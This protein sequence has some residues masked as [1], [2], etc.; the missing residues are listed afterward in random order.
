MDKIQ[1]DEIYNQTFSGLALFYRDTN[2]PE[3]LISKYTVGQILQE[4]G[5]T[6]MTFKVGGLTTNLRY[7]IASAQA[8]DLSAFNPVSANFGLCLLPAGAFFKVLDIYRIGDKTQIFMLDIPAAAVGFFTVGSTNIEDG[9]IKKAREN[10]ETNFNAP[11]VPELQ[12]DEWKQRTEFPVGMSDK[13]EFFYNPDTTTTVSLN[14]TDEHRVI[15]AKRE[16]QQKPW[17]KFW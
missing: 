15:Q 8:T 10:F 7:L 11:P 6:D 3:E 14:S 2:L 4:R 16:K 5:F 12:A 17:W 13:G 1:L 9:I